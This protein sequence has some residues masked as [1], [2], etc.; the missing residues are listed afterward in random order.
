MR[1][2]SIRGTATL[3]T[4]ATPRG[5]E[6][7]GGRAVRHFAVIAYDIWSILKGPRRPMSGAA[8]GLLGIQ[9]R[10]DQTAA[11]GDPSNLKLSRR[12]VAA[13]E[14]QRSAG[15][16]SVFCSASGSTN[17]MSEGGMNSSS[18]WW[19]SGGCRGARGIRASNV[20]CR[21]LTPDP[22]TAIQAVTGARV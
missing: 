11:L 17:V 9:R 8:M 18:G 7:V 3:W 16:P 5:K 13:N 1:Y 14:Q 22:V 2:V 6:E 19:V 12:P 10:G 15:Q 4:S 20:A 21:G